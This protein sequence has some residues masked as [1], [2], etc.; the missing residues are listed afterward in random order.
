[1]AETGLP[2]GG[3]GDRISFGQFLTS[4]LDPI[5][6]RPLDTPQ[7]TDAAIDTSTD[8]DVDLSSALIVLP[9]TSGSVL[10]PLP[11]PAESIPDPIDNNNNLKSTLLPPSTTTPPRR[12]TRVFTG[13]T[14]DSLP[15]GLSDGVDVDLR[16]SYESPTRFARP[17]DIA[18]IQGMR[19]LGAV[20]LSDTIDDENKEYGLEGRGM[21]F[22]AGSDLE[23]NLN[24]PGVDELLAEEEKEVL[25]TLTFEQVQ[26]PVNQ[27]G[28]DQTDIRRTSF[29]VRRRSDWAGASGSGSGSI[30][31]KRFEEIE[32]ML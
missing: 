6:I 30:A 9:Y 14:S 5:L 31:K 21:A 13:V 20:A 4:Q 24:L 15:Q 22:T 26:V 1:M 10:P 32:A 16:L 7:T 28:D 3:V 18:A 23:L 12:F 27:M 25:P 17:R 2:G 11:S 19:T 8:I 29:G